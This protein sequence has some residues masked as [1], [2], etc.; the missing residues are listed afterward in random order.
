MKKFLT[1]MFSFILMTGCIS[2]AEGD[3]WDNF[4]DQHTY[5]Q[6]AVSD[7]E[8]D[9]ALKSKKGKKN[10]RNRAIPKGSEFH[11]SNE[12]QF[13]K[14]A[15]EE[16]PIL[17]VPVTLRIGESTIPVG[18]YQIDGERS[19]NKVFLKFYQAH[20]LIAKV[21]AIETRDDFGKETVH[22]VE[23]RGINE[24]QVKVIFGSIDFNAYSIIDI[25]E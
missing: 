6:K 8:F 25:A 15:E 13:I 14:E 21:P 20:Y 24:T 7:K 1:I 9:D 23:L 22:F 19:G 10:K 3:L 17:C 2:Y 11:Q 16:M 12:T 18:H 5:G 4:G